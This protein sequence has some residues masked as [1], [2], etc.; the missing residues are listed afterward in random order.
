MGEGAGE[1]RN[2]GGKRLPLPEVELRR[3]YEAGAFVR[4]LASDYHVSQRLVRKR[5]REAGT[6]MRP[7]GTLYPV[8]T[9]ELLRDLYLGQGMTARRIA[10]RVGCSESTVTWRLRAYRIPQRHG[11]KKKSSTALAQRALLPRSARQRAA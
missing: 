2:R 6:R 7:G 3:A 1:G 11:G 4:Q 10:A 9:R 8:L 5:L